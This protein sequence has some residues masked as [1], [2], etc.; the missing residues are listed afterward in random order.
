MGTME[1]GMSDVNAGMIP[2]VFVDLFDQLGGRI[3]PT[4][5]SDPQAPRP[6]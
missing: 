6:S 5:S 1:D 2:R 4:E 3:K